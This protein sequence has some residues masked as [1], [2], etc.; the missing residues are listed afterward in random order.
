[1]SKQI[2][3]I[4]RKNVLCVFRNPIQL[5]HASSVANFQFLGYDLVE[6]GSADTSALSNCG[7]YPDVFSNS[8][9][10]EL[11]LLTTFDRARE[12]QK[13]LRASHP[14][15]PHANCDLWAIFRVVE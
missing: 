1:L 14:E 8:E 15:E 11:G 13:T 12:V 9:L 4:A 10:S 3:S 2:Q 5:P 7:G 6:T